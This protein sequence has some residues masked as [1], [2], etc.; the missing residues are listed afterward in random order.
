MME[1]VGAIAPG[2]K[3]NSL[4]FL[5]LALTDALTN[6]LRTTDP[7]IY[8]VVMLVPGSVIY[9]SAFLLLPIAALQSESARWRQKINGGLKFLYKNST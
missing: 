4:L 2:L 5:V 7:A 9:L 8:L 3:L 6:N 1:L